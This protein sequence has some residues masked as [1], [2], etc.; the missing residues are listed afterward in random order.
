MPPLPP[1]AL[2]VIRLRA[3]RPGSVPAPT[4][5]PTPAPTPR[6]GLM[7]CFSCTAT[8]APRSSASSLAMASR[9]TP[10]ALRRAASTSPGGLPGTGRRASGATALGSGV[11]LGLGC[12]TSGLAVVGVAGASGAALT[13]GG[14]G[15]RSST[16]LARRGGSSTS[17]VRSSTGR[18]IHNSTRQIR[19]LVTR[20]RRRIR[21][22]RASSAGAMAHGSTEAR[23]EI[24]AAALTFSPFVS[25]RTTRR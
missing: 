22:K 17:T 21:L 9:P 20:T 23:N 14:S 16:S 18:G 2:E 25:L 4:P 15:S 11:A 13:G 1:V 24:D 19:P 6:P 5:T 8:G 12:A 7:S 3:G 10:A